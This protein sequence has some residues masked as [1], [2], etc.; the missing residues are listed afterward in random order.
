MIMAISLFAVVCRTTAIE[1][2]AGLFDPEGRGHSAT[3]LG[4]PSAAWPEVCHVW[5][6]ELRPAAAS[7]IMGPPDCHRSGGAPMSSDGS[8]TRWVTAL[9]GGDAAA[10]QPLW[11]R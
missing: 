3:P 7:P 10:A 2:V 11:E 9:K 5:R 8:I 4:V 1:T 6:K